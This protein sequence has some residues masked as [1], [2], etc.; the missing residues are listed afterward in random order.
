MKLSLRRDRT[1]NVTAALRDEL[2]CEPRWMYAWE[3]GEGLEVPLLDPELETIHRTRVDLIEPA[4]RS[5]LAAAGARATALDLAC[6]EGYFSHLLLEW[7]ARNVVGMD[8]REENIRRATLVRDHLGVPRERLDFRR[9]D[10]FSL[11][12]E[13]LGRFDVVLLLG[14]VYHLEDPVGAVRRARTFT[15]GLCVIESQLTRHDAPI[16]HHWGVSDAPISAPASF[17][18]HVERDSVQNP[19]AS[20]PGVLSL[21][22]NAAALELMAR[23]AGFRHTEFVP[24]GSQHHREYVAGDRGVLIAKP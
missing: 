22:P 16:E 13:K 20:V 10:L 6:S 24:V 7:G 12:P 8:V 9:A 14:L 18:A 2:R 15:R 17:A 1:A 3:L 19:I 21:V 11:D 23:V 5:A 4:V